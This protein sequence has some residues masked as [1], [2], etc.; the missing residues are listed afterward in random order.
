MF[1]WLLLFCIKQAKF[2][3]GM[4]DREQSVVFVLSQCQGPAEPQQIC[5]WSQ[6]GLCVHTCSVLHLQCL[7]LSLRACFSSKDQP[8]STRYIIFSPGWLCFGQNTGGENASGCV[9]QDLSFFSDVVLS[10]TVWKEVFSNIAVKQMSPLLFME[11][12][13]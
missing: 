1:S 8:T 7:L 11:H 9:K 3:L 2:S 5:A 4:S 13:S 12:C 10:H 6:S